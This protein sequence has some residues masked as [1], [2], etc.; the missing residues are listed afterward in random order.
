LSQPLLIGIQLLWASKAHTAPEWRN[1]LN[2]DD[3]RGL[4]PLLYAHVNPYGSFPLTQF[5]FSYDQHSG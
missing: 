1:R 5:L 4:T 2:T 3:L